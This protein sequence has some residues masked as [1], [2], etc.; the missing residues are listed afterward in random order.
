MEIKINDKVLPMAK[1]WE[2]W[3]YFSEY[4]DE[5]NYGYIIDGKGPY[6]DPRSFYQPNGVHGLSRTYGHGSFMWLDQDWKQP[7]FSDSIIYE[8]HVG[9]FTPEGTFEAAAQK[10]DY[11]KELGVTHIEVMPVN[12]FAGKRGWGY[13]GVNIFAPHHIYGGPDGFKK[14]INACHVKE[15]GVILDVVYNHFGLE[16]NYI[17]KF[18]PYFSEKYKTIWGNAYNFDY[19]YSYEPRRLIID[20]AL[21]WLRDYHLDGLRL[22][23]VHSIYDQSA[24]HILEQLAKEVEKL[25]YETGKFYYLIAESDLNNPRLVQNFNI[26]GYGFDATWNDDFHH[27]LHAALTGERNG[28]YEDFGE[29]ADIG[30]SLKAV[31]VYDGKYSRY[32][33]AIHGRAAEHCDGNNFVCYIQN[34]DQVGNRA[35][36]ERISHLVSM[37][38]AKIGAAMVLT[39]PF[40]P[41]IFQGEEFAASSPFQYFTDVSDEKLARGIT[42]GRKNEF[43]AFGWRPEEVPD[44]QSEETFLRSKLN[45]SEI[46]ERP[47][48]SMLEWYK[49]LIQLRKENAELRSGSLQDVNVSFN[50]KEKIIEVNRGGGIKL[51]ADLGDGELEIRNQDEMILNLEAVHS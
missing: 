37:E 48:K 6:P 2:W 33:K 1:K 11:L 40:V 23:A 19:K 36:G 46:E 21:M 34:H 27:A 28:Y 32:R 8:I 18:G 25:E 4:A 15:M 24:I 14:F 39:A 51:K 13:D 9:T 26:G 47:H 30:K 10:I 38:K 29:T 7:A 44:P 16:G 49:Y 43:G 45:W 20:N 31:Y 50:E 35:M 22:D 42:Q 12:E 5:C 17:E 41:M 3:E